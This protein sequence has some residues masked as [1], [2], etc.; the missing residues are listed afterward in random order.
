[1]MTAQY[2]AALHSYAEG[3]YEEAMQQFSELL[4]EDPRNPKLHIWLGAT[5]RKAGKIEY[6]KVQYQQ[7]LTLT[8]DPDLLDLASTSLA[9]IQNKLA[10]S[11]QKP[12]S[13][14]AAHKDLDSFH[15]LDDSS[16]QQEIT[17]VMHPQS[18]VILG[19]S[20]LVDKA[21]ASNSDL[22]DS[23]GDETV[24]ASNSSILSNN[25]VSKPQTAIKPSNGL[26]PPPPAIAALLENKLQAIIPEEPPS[27]S[28]IFSDEPTERSANSSAST[29]L[30]ASI[31]QDTIANLQ[32]S[33]SKDKKTKRSKKKQPQV[34]FPPLES[35]VFIDAG[36]QGTFAEIVSNQSTSSTNSAIALEDMLKF[37]TVG[38]KITLWGALVA[39]IPAVI[40]GVT[41]YKV[42]DGLLL[43][44]V[45]QGQQSEAIALAKTTENF[46]HR[47]TGDVG[48]LKTLL[49]SAEVGQNTLQNAGQSTITTN[50]SESNKTIKLLASL[51]INQQRQYKQLLTNR[52]NLYS[53]A[54]P[55]Y[56]SIA[57]F[58]TNG[59]LLAQSNSSKTL[60]TINPN[61]LNK[62]ATADNILIGNPVVDKNGT[63]L[64]AVTSVKS[65]V[66]Q[67]VG[68]ILQV[69]IPVKS[70]VSELS[71]N[72]NSNGGS[73]FYVIDNANKY[74]A[75]SQPVTLAEDA[76]TDFAML[77]SLR[78]LPSNDLPVKGD[79]NPQIIAYAPIANMQ[80]YGMAWDIVT[81]IDKATA[82]SGNQNLLLVIGIG[83][84]ATPLLVAA[85]AYALSRR[86][87]N[88]LK[89]I[90]SALRNLSRGNTDISFGNLSV[91]G[92]DELADISLSINKMSDQFQVMMQK[93][94][95]ERQR[96]QAQ[97]VKM[98]KVLSK[99]AREEK[100]EVQEE[101]LSD[102]N[103]MQLGKKIRGEMVQRN[104][105]VESYRQQK[106]DLQ[107]QLMQM[108]K[109]V[110]ALADGDLTVATKSI[111]GN[112]NNVS[113]FFDDVIRGL[114][115]I[116]GQVKSSASQV[117]LSLGQNEQAI[118]NLT[119][120]S[121]RQV[122]TVTRSL[123]TV[124]MAK[125]SASSITTNSQNVL[126]SSQMVAEKLSESDRSIDAVMAKV[127]ELQGTVANT[128][129]RV[130][131]LGEVSQKIAKAIS[132][133][134]EIAIKTNFLAINATL[135]ASRSGDMGNGF[136][137]V[138][139]EVGELAARSVAATKEV[140]GL[141][142]SIQTEA[143][144]VMMAV[145]SGSNQAAESATLAISAKDSL[146]QISHISQQIDDLVSSISDATI[147]QVQTSEGVANLMKDIS[148]IAKRNLAASSEVSKFLKSTKRY[149]GDLQQALAQFKTR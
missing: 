100:Q 128:A 67:K 144:A 143:N 11:A 47:Q 59:E 34:E 20:R 120:V 145:E 107:A 29:S 93:Q 30:P 38:Q 92:N 60:Q 131:H 18:N 94:E 14:K 140:E 87:S 54:Y 1:M 138:A 139:E 72:R 123:N 110:Q 19:I 31:L 112:L 102:Q 35:E 95:Q 39:T 84:A 79:R 25:N 15:K 127:G 129:K 16:S 125:I 121:Q 41:A 13:K 73:N 86:L 83:I 9:Q 36:E 101:D 142:N 88:R 119:S 17:Q 70:L 81:T 43:T 23:S 141:L 22:A 76:L 132:A 98:F 108:L 133:I 80:S 115:N 116:V 117:N 105:E 3:R 68:M 6:A 106:S 111:D 78:S 63:Y 10:H 118:A 109:D 77:P 124:Q 64:Y 8:D 104:A 147:S 56:T 40:L 21:I 45:K 62:A 134:N 136:A 57:I 85:I 82:I 12:E 52:L 74:I 69:E 148:H 37:S 135:E 26:V 89:D 65:S 61:L 42:G 5:F 7:V 126:K 96:L 114:Q 24:L 53:Q 149:S 113:I 48:V 130:K 44:K 32:N 27:E 137:M 49:V 51:P 46:L 122:D 103:I 90:R 71:S 33:N 146:L 4:Y 66:S 55:Q 2:Q 50:P 91:E 28:F 99:L 75:S 97:V 58:S